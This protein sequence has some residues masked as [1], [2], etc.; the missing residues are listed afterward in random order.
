MNIKKSI[1]VKSSRTRLSY[2]K[3]L[4]L[5]AADCFVKQ[6][7]FYSAAKQVEAAALTSRDM[8]DFDQV[9]TLFERASNLFV[10]HRCALPSIVSLYNMHTMND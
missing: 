8:K 6:G 5:Q 2:P 9:S 1:S 4:L 7:S 10:Q 3:S